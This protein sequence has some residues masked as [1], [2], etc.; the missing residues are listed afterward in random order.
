[1]RLSFQVRAH[2]DGIGRI[3]G[4]TAFLYVL[5]LALLVH[6]KGG[7]VGKLGVVV[8]HAIGFSDLTLHIAEQREFYANLFRECGVRGYCVNADAEDFGV[9]QI[10]FPGV[11]TSLVSLQFLRSA[12]GEG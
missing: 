5:D 7:A 2:I 9:V 6:D 11:D 1:V 12:T 4:A 3:N 8:Q 10:D